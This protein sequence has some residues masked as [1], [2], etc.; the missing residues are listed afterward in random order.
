MTPGERT[1]RRKLLTI[2]CRRFD[3]IHQYIS[4]TSYVGRRQPLSLSKSPPTMT[5]VRFF[6]PRWPQAVIAYWIGPSIEIMNLSLISDEFL[7]AS[8][9]KPSALRV[10]IAK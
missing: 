5:K 8:T 10:S 2:S 7:G 4:G 1:A 9:A 6:S 3:E